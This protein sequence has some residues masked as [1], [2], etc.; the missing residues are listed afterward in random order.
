ME[1]TTA[2]PETAAP[3]PKARKASKAKP[4]PKAKAKPVASANG[5]PKARDKRL[6]SPGSVIKRVYKDKEYKVKVKTDSFELGGKEY[7]SLTAVA[8]AIIKS[9]SEINGFAFFKL[10]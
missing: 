9:D 3:A 10:A 2:T 5:K 4:K 1:P 6:P 7:G 8:K